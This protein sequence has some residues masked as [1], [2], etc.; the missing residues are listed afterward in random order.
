MGQHDVPSYFRGIRL[1][2]RRDIWT[3]TFGR[4]HLAVEIFGRSDFLPHRLSAAQTFCRK[5]F[6][7]ERLFAVRIWAHPGKI[8]NKYFL[9]EK[10][11]LFLVN[12]KK[13]KD[14]M[15]KSLGKWVWLKVSLGKYV[16]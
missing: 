6:F 5:D 16:E 9:V 3:Q 11:V 10:C 15:R 1:L 7:P 12:F 13:E 8:I 2:W 14:G 4:N